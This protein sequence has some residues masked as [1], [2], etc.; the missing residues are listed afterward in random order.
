MEH[1]KKITLDM[2]MA[3]A[4]QRKQAEKVYLESYSEALGGNLVVEKIGLSR[5]LECM[6]QYDVDTFAGSKE[7]SVDIIYMSCP[8]LRNPEV[9]AAF[10]CSEPSDIVS[11]VLDDNMKDINNIVADIKSMYG[12]ADGKNEV[13]EVKN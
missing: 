5:I 8:M 9:Q 1:G 12:M 2:L 10:G 7:A 6:D 13:D 4:E 3:K 11:A